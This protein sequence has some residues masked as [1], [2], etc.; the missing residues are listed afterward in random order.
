MILLKQN[1][2]SAFAEFDN[3]IIQKRRMGD[4]L[5]PRNPRLYRDGDQG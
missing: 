5:G 2:S 1:P 3:R 4:E